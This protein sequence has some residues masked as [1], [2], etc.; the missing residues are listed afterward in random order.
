MI[1]IVTSVCVDVDEKDDANYPMLKGIDDK[2]I[3]YWRCCM[4]FFMTSTKYNYDANHIVYTNDKNFKRRSIHGYN[5]K[6]TLEGLGVEIVELPFKKFDP[7]SYS[8]SFRNAFY[9]HEVIEA[10]SKK[11]NPSILLDS[12]CIWTKRCEKLIGKLKQSDGLLLQDTYQRSSNPKLKSPHNLSMNDMGELYKEIPVMPNQTDNPIWYGGELIGG[13]PKNL[14]TVA[15]G[16]YKTLKYCQEQEDLQKNS[17]V[18]N[19]GNSIFSNDE[20]ISSYVFNAL[21][22]IPVHDTFGTISKRMWTLDNLYNVGETDLN[23]PI[24]HLPAEKESGLKE[25]FHELVNTESIFW[26]ST[27][28]IPKFVGNFF[29]IP[30]NQVSPAKKVKYFLVKCKNASKRLL[31]I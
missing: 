26:T 3:V 24:W 9:K 16:L 1:N 31:N 20:F 6:D 21:E 19:N 2:S 18:F 17:M 22:G 8:K 29:N 30:K 7:K 14:K 10:L 28:P 13:Q 25:L 4:T 15:D 27:E 12:D 11:N 5:L 23:L